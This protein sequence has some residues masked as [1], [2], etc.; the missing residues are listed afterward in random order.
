MIATPSSFGAESHEGWKPAVR[1]DPWQP[2]RSWHAIEDDEPTILRRELARALGPSHRTPKRDRLR[3][4]FLDGARTVAQLKR[5]GQ[6]SDE[7][8]EVLLSALLTFFSGAMV[9]QLAQG[10]F[11]AHRA[12]RYS[13][14]RW[15][16]DKAR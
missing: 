1:A 9:H 3:R 16:L 11:H 8:A 15:L 4:A 7:D 6:I 5:D 2:L 12:S 13:A 10:T 14:Q